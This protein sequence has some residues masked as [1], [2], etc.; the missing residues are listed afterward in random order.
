VRPD[1]RRCRVAEKTLTGKKVAIL[2]ADNVERVELEEA[3][4]E[5]MIELFAPSVVQARAAAS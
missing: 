2:A 3:S 5:K 1:E 4:N